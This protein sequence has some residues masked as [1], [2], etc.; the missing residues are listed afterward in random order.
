MYI[1]MTRLISRIWKEL[2]QITIKG[3]TTQFLSGQ[4]ILY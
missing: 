4:Q 1:H 3:Q 2:P